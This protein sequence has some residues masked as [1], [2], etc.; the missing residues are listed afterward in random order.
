MDERYSDCVDKLLEDGKTIDEICGAFPEYDDQ[1]RKYCASKSI[2][3]HADKHLAQDTRQDVASFDKLGKT[4]GIRAKTDGPNFGLF[5]PVRA[6]I[7]SRRAFFVAAA[8]F[9]LLVV[10]NAA[11]LAAHSGSKPLSQA[12]NENN[13]SSANAKSQETQNITPTEG[14]QSSSALP[15]PTGKIDDTVAQ[16]DKFAGQEDYIIAVESDD[17]K[18][19]L[20]DN[21][22]IDNFSTIYSGSA[23]SCATAQNFA[24]LAKKN[25][26]DRA[27]TLSVAQAGRLNTI[28]GGRNSRDNVLEAQRSTTDSLLQRDYDK[29]MLVAEG[30]VQKQGIFDF[31]AAV[32]AAISARRVAIDAAQTGF[33]AGL[34]QILS[35]RM[36]DIKKATDTLEFAIDAALNQA[37]ADCKSGSDQSATSS[38]LQNTINQ[39]LA[40]FDSA[41]SLIE[42][43]NGDALVGAR[44]AALKNANDAF[45]LALQQVA[46]NLKALGF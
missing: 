18:L 23:F 14:D 39:D 1:I 10:A 21:G 20:S 27:S 3:K 16:I 42:S 2:Q 34:D 31:H 30:G 11:W 26:V 32:G 45:G 44:V 7:S 38:R 36:A 9:V 40:S 19:I 25:E 28:I 12:A 13:S 5:D 4:A 24:T 41:R 15:E 37:A 29:M 22:A 43:Q 46:Q 33:R 17:S 35:Q 8:I 6:A